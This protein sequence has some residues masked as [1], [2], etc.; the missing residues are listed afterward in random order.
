[1]A[2]AV[3]LNGDQLSL[4]NVLGLVVC[5]GGICCHVIHK[6]STMTFQKPDEILFE[7]TTNGNIRDN[8]SQSVVLHSVSGQKMPL[9]ENT[10]S[11]DE[12]HEHDD[13]N[14]S[15]VIFDVLKRR[16]SSRR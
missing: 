4:M 11:E 9:L 3:E 8:L 6:Y 14:A 13:Q 5:L 12:S 16:D 7:E 15:E 10:D 1:M 2:L